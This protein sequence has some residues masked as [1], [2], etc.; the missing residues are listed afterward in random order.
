MISLY[1]GS[2]DLARTPEGNLVVSDSSN[3]RIQVLSP[4]GAP[5]RIIE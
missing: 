5:L 2:Q 3:H 1:M 4:A